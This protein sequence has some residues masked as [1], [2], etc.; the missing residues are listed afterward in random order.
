MDRKLSGIRRFIKRQQLG[1]E[2]LVSLGNKGCDCLIIHTFSLLIA[3]FR[4]KRLLSAFNG[5]VNNSL[6]FGTD[7][8]IRNFTKEI[9]LKLSCLYLEKHD[10]PVVS[11]FLLLGWI[12]SGLMPIS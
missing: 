12:V 5:P 1:E 9:E 8:S 7:K 6:G 11:D 3:T 10:K 4:E 2:S